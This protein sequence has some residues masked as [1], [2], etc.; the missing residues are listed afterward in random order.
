MA[1]DAIIARA[2]ETRE[3]AA[4][5]D[6][7]V[8]VWCPWVPAY[9]AREPRVPA[10]VAI[11]CDAKAAGSIVGPADRDRRESTRGLL[12]IEVLA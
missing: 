4:E 10:L 5:R 11:I 7:L 12:P 1:L 9:V 3:R 6:G 2:D 8:G